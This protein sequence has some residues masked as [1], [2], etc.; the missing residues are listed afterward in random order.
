MEAVELDPQADTESWVVGVQWHPEQSQDDLRLFAGLV[1]AAQ[2][3]SL[4]V[5][6]DLR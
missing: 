2:A 4:K 1:E 5:P 3:R 6:S